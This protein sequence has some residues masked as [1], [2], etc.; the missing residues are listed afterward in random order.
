MSVAE[1]TVRPSRPQGRSNAWLGMLAIVQAAI[2]VFVLLTVARPP[3]TKTGPLLGNGVQTSDITAF[4][5]TGSDGSKVSLERDGTQWVLPNQGGYPAKA[6]RVKSFLQ[7]L[8]GLQRSGLVATTKDAYKRLKVTSDTFQRKI[9]L[10]LKGGKTETLYI[11]SEP[12]YG[13]THVRLASGK[14]VYVT[15]SFHASDARTDAAG[16]VDPIAL[17]LNEGDVTRLQLK[18]ANGDFVFTKGS[19]GWAMQGV[20]GGKTFDPTSINGI[21]SSLTDLQLD[22]PLGK[23]A[24]P[25]YGLDKPLAVVTLTTVSKQTASGGSGGSAAGGASGSSSSTA[26]ASTSKTAASTSNAAASTSNAASGTAKTATAQA[27]AKAPAKTVTKTVTKTTTITVG[28]KDK[29]GFYPIRI[30]GSPFIVRA[31]GASLGDVVGKKAGDFYAKPKASSSGISS[32]SSG[33]AGGLGSL[34]GAPGAG[35][36]GSASGQ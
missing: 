12:S 25:A 18:N 23:T 22:E 15:H 21:L 3:S 27:P 29:S 5:V 10:T 4:T 17:T 28:A 2:L 14:G 13:S 7:E 6:S 31:S 30:S 33:A 34:G 20:P 19:A 1:R 11:G 35:Q 24:K 36:G 16:Y 8:V 26:A 9:A 32:G